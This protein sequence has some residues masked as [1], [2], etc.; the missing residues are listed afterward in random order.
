MLSVNFKINLLITKQEKTSP[1]KLYNLPSDPPLAEGKPLE[2]PEERV[3]KKN[4]LLNVIPK[5]TPAYRVKFDFK[6]LQFQSG[7]TNIIHLTQDGNCCKAGQRIPAV[8]FYSA[9]STATKNKLLL[10]SAVG[11]TGK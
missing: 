2:E 10:C 8:F 5:L 6:P 7:W 4:N 11:N 1:L 3:N 9:A